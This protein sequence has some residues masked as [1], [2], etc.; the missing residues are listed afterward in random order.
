MDP[1]FLGLGT[2]WRR[3]VSFTPLPLYP[4]GKSTRYA[5]DEA[6]WARAIL[7]GMDKLKFLTVSG[8]EL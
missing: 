5:S 1:R 2:S 6:G 7:D 8:I 3:V 4:R